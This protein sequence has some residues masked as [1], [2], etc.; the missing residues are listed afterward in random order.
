M[1]LECEGHEGDESNTSPIEEYSAVAHS[2]SWGE[3]VQIVHL[4]RTPRP[5]RVAYT[6]SMGPTAKFIF[7]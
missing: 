4:L 5:D 6:T 7:E 3:L 1:G 2:E